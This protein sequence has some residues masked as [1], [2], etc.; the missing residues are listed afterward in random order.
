MGLYETVLH[1][2]SVANSFFSETVFPLCAV[3]R[4][5]FFMLHIVWKRG[6]TWYM[7]IDWIIKA[8]DLWAWM[9]L[10]CRCKV[11]FSESLFSSSGDSEMPVVCDN[12]SYWHKFSHIWQYYIILCNI[13]KY[14][15]DHCDF[16]L[17]S[18]HM[19]ESPNVVPDGSTSSCLEKRSSTLILWILSLEFT[20]ILGKLP[21]VHAGD[22]GTI[23]YRYRGI[24]RFNRNVARADSAPGSKNGSPNGPKVFCKFL[25]PGVAVWYENEGNMLW[26]ALCV[27]F[28]VFS[29]IA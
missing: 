17:Y 26:K 13:H 2:Y 8:E 19:A 12:R 25:G 24:N 15:H 18:M 9:K 7:A 4:S 14:I 28:S 22:T 27:L 16:W 6:S 10:S 20:S 29:N 21:T 1:L 23:S 3:A 5:I 11:N